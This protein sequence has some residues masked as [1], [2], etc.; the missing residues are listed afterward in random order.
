MKHVLLRQVNRFF[1]GLQPIG[2]EI[3]TIITTGHFFSLLGLFSY[4]SKLDR[5]CLRLTDA[6]DGLSAG[7]VLPSQRS[8]GLALGQP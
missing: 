7:A 4:P 6:H 8:N 2:G 3:T 1:A 5:C